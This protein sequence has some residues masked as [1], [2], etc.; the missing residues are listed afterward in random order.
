MGLHFKALKL[1]IYKRN[2]NKKTTQ[3]KQTPL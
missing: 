1:D 2:N 3:N